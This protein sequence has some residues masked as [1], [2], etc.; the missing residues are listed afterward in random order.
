[1][2]IRR[3]QKYGTPPVKLISSFTARHCTMT[4]LRGIVIAL[5][6]LWMV[7]ALSIVFADGQSAPQV[8]DSSAKTPVKVSSTFAR[9][10]IAP[11][12]TRELSVKPPSTGNQGDSQTSSSTTASGIRSVIP[13]PV[14]TTSIPTAEPALV[15]GNLDNSASANT[16][17]QWGLAFARQGEYKAAMEEFEKALAREPQN[18]NTWY[19]L[20]ICAEALGYIEQ[21]HNAYV[22]VLQ[23]DPTFVPVANIGGESVLFSQIQTN[24]TS[25]D[26]VV[27]ES[28][29]TQ[30]DWV[31]ATFLLGGLLVIFLGSAYIIRQPNSKLAAL[32]GT[33]K[34]PQ[35]ALLSSEK[36]DEMADTTM[37]YFKGDRKVIVKLLTIASEIASEGR[38]GKH[39]GTA[40]IIGDADEVLERSRP[41]ILNPFEGHD[42]ES[43]SICDRDTHE[44]IKEVAQMDGAF[45]ISDKGVII[46]A[47]RYIS[48]DTSEVDVPRGLGTRH[49]STG[50]IT[51]ATDA[52]GIVV[53]ES[54]GTIRVFADGAIIASNVS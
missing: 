32:L 46:A 21:A 20:G 23:L 29:N 7:S 18:L 22:Y 12:E 6:I 47:G 36:I 50:A 17:L 48:I 1:M 26:Q 49:V 52:I 10:M 42:E 34:T 41:L 3:I 24:I 11:L 39:V 2:K 30:R 9:A 31:M 54:G 5:T 38:E 28:G 13:T 25:P 27:E 40:F 51:K 35:R 43:R 37:K 14:R 15:P 8:I 33:A 53:S 19:Y 4:N 16:Y 45:I 44:S